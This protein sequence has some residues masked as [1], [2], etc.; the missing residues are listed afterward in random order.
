MENT[1]KP[2]IYFKGRIELHDPFFPEPL[3]ISKGCSYYL[4]MLEAWSYP[5]ECGISCYMEGKLLVRSNPH[6][7][8]IDFC[9][10]GESLR[11]AVLK[12]KKKVND[13]IK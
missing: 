9:Y 4:D 3:V 12:A 6:T 5:L 11:D 8:E 13:L 7:L 2:R 1:K 10:R